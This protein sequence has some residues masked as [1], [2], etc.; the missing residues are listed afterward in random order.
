MESAAVHDECAP[1]DLRRAHE[2]FAKSDALAEPQRP[3]LFGDEG[4]RAALDDEPVAPFGGDGATET[5]ATFEQRQLD[6][7]VP[8]AAQL[9]DAVCR[10]HTG[11]A[12]AHHGDPGYP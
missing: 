9:D 1:M 12:A 5:I 8:F 7:C 11:D 10:G 2:P 3:R 6:G 4:I